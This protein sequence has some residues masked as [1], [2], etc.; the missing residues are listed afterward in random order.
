MDNIFCMEIKSR[1]ES[2]FAGTDTADLFSLR[3][4]LLGTCGIVDRGI[5]PAG[6]NRLRIGCVDDGI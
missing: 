5:S 2:R 6:V 1:C 4:K 3:K